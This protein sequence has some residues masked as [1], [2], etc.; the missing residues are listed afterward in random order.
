MEEQFKTI[1][2][3]GLY[4]VSDQGRVKSFQRCGNKPYGILKPG[5]HKQG[6]KVV[7]I[8]NDEGKQKG[9]MIHQLVAYAFLSHVPERGVVVVDHIDNNPSNNFL[10][11]LQIISCR[12]NVSKDRKNL[13]ICYYKPTNRFLAYWEGTYVGVYDTE[14]E[15]K[16]GQSLY[17]QTGQK[18][19][20]RSTEGRVTTYSIMLNSPT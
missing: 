12:E 8:K 10:S 18:K 9:M 19:V 20:L 17:R 11:N 3:F 4:E 15:A 7:I 6:Y 14:E 1:P 5:T 13:G 16:E 2:G